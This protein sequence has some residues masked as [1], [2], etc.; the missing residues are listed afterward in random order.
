MSKESALCIDRIERIMALVRL[1]DL[2]SIRLLQKRVRTAA[3][4]LRERK[5]IKSA[6]N[7]KYYN[8]HRDEKIAKVKTYQQR[9]NPYVGLKRLFTIA[10]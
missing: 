8:A 7:R 3:A 9:K 2:E 4:G 10:E 1:L 5:G 6:Y